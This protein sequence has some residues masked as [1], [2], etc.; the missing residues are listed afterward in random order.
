MNPRAALLATLAVLAATPAV[1]QDQHPRGTR[2]KS[3]QTPHY[4]VIAPAE[5]VADAQRVANLLEHAWGPTA[6]T[7]GVQSKRIPVVLG[8]QTTEANA[9][10]ASA[11]RFSEWYSTPPQDAFSG[12]VEWYALLAA[13]ELR[14]VAQGDKL[15]RGFAGLMG[16]VFGPVGNTLVA[17]TL[18]PTWFWEGDATGTETALT[19][20]GR[21]RLP[22]FDMRTRA[23]VLSG[24]IRP[25]HTA[26]RGTFR[27]WNPGP[28]EM[29]YLL[30]T[31]VKRT[32][33]A[34]AWSRVL[35]HTSRRGYR[36]GAFGAALKAETGKDAEGLYR[37]AL[38]E[39]EGL[40][41]TQIDG[42][43]FTGGRVLN[44]APRGAWTNYTE[45]Q[46]LPDGA[47]IASKAGI[48]DTRALVRID[49][50][51]RERRLAEPAIGSGDRISAAAGRVVWAE[52]RQD[53]RWG[54]RSFTVI[55]VLDTATGATRDLGAPGKWFSPALSPDGSR[56]AV[57]EFGADRRAALVVLDAESGALEARIALAT[58][59]A[60]LTPAW[61]PDG[62]SVVG[63]RQ[64]RDG[65]AVTRWELATGT[66]TDLVPPG[67]E[68]IT[69]PTLHGEHLLF[70]SPRSGIDNVYAL[71]LP[72]RREFQV[73]S[74][75]FG[76]FNAALSA[77]GTRLV[78]QD[79][80][81]DGFDLVE[82]PWEPA[83]WT[84]AEQVEDRGIRYYEPLIAQE[85]G[86]DIFAAVPEQ[87]YPV[88]DYNAAADLIQ[89]VE[90]HLL[91]Y[92]GG[93]DVGIVS[94]NLLNTLETAASVGYDNGERTGY[95][96]VTAS[97]SGAYPIVDFGMGVGGRS[98]TLD[99]AGV[100][101]RTDRWRERSVLL[102]VRL[103]LDLSR[104][105]EGRSAYLGVR[106]E[107]IGVS[108]LDHVRE[109]GS[110]N[111][112][113][114]PLTYEAAFGRSRPGLR[115]DLVGRG[116]RSV[117]LAYTHTPLPGDFQGR[118]LVARGA[119]S[120]PGLARHH[121]TVVRIGWEAQDAGGYRFGSETRFPRGFDRVFHPR[122]ASASAD[123]LLPLAYPDRR[124]GSAATLQRVTGTLFADHAAGSGSGDTRRYTSA[125]AELAVDVS[126]FNFA[127]PV[128]LG[129]RLVHLFGS[130]R[131][132]VEPVIGV[133]F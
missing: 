38:A 17:H 7:L 120:L 86:G 118:H 40:W 21:G 23:E 101:G 93:F 110:G 50:N 74:R 81:P 39:L 15:N 102:G 44:T 65:A 47:W 105:I 26:L 87:V 77:D 73:T 131:V 100:Q 96:E 31:Y 34:D 121:G 14:H 3:I 18:V 4:E 6:K 104:G 20:G 79:Y 80:T 130:G 82:M 112:A 60:L 36:P 67:Y 94:V 63:V 113:F 8:N 62:A 11:P 129:A 19:R 106:G 13:H 88:A 16:R 56:V 111:G 115:R 30:T 61:S 29:G 69:R 126:F 41:R 27:T 68:S 53:A 99:S 128:R 132:A 2:W 124:L 49:P 1:A 95:A 114:L 108:G 107:W 58:G 48:H 57:A 28:Y 89:P 72:T 12:P 51:G 91:P 54:K 46:P 10:V 75:R 52:G 90:R 22:S 78:F 125:G 119:L 84:P 33:G 76:A 83:R 25:Y 24:R 59:D 37:A 117:R 43:H 5:L 133:G 45:P 42:L 122:L 64:T 123:Y 92:P 71:H 85:A 103:P 70:N 127:A 9:L 35:D 55:R 66:A 98:T 116:E 32:H 109:T 97:Y